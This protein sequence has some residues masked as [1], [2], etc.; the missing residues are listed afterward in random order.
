M[1]WLLIVLSSIII[2]SCGTFNTSNQ[3]SK[4][5]TIITTLNT[6]YHVNK[7]NNKNVSDYNLSITFNNDTKQ[8]SGFLGCNRFVG[9]FKQEGDSLAIGDLGL[10]RIMCDEKANNI[11]KEFRQALNKI[12]TLTQKNDALLLLNNNTVLIQATKKIKKNTLTFEYTTSTRSAY[13][14]IKIDSTGTY[15]KHKRGAKPDSKNI[16]KSSW[17]TLILLVEQID[18]ETLSSLE[19][20]SKDHQFDGAA[21]AHFKIIKNNITYQVA[22]FDA[23]KP[24]TV[25]APLVKEILS[26]AKNI[27]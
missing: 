9:T 17:D 10:T 27:E 14:A 7:L 15:I 3:N 21:L 8:V 16:K 23:G 11:E 1:K 26:I 24:H 2:E 12:N 18:I 19:P 6:T 4:D 25:I 20:P 22:P 5:Y 13:Q